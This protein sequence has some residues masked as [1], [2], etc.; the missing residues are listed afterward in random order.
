MSYDPVGWAGP[1]L[2][3]INLGRAGS[4]RVV[5]YKITRRILL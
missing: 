3:K 4:L 1:G 2:A 5:V